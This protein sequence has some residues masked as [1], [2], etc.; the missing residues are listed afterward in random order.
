MHGRWTCG[1]DR[2]ARQIASSMGEESNSVRGYV[3][4]GFKQSYIVPIHKIRDCR[5]KVMTYDDFREI[6]IAR[7]GFRKGVGCS[8]A[9]Q[10]VRN[11]VDQYVCCF[12]FILAL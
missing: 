8:H 5:T 12:N 3:P 11:V 10:T 2:R 7:F 9:I 6:T 4:G 1:L